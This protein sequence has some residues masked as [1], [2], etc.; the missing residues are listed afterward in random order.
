MSWPG[1]AAP[2]TS[3]SSPAATAS[4]SRLTAPADA[5]SSNDWN[6]TR[7]HPSEEARRT[8]AFSGP[9][10][11]SQG[12]TGSTCSRPRRA[13]SPR[14]TA[15]TTARTPASSPP[16]ASTA[17]ATCSAALAPAV[18]NAS[19]RALACA[20]SDGCPWMRVHSASPG[21]GGSGRSASP[22]PSSDT[23]VGLSSCDPSVPLS[24]PSDE[25]APRTPSM[26]APTPAPAPVPA[27]ALAPCRDGVGAVVPA[28]LIGEGVQSPAASESASHCDAAGME[29]M[30]GAEGTWG[31]GGGRC[32][33]EEAA[34]SRLG[35]APPSANSAA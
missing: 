27:P 8:R 25:P 33:G 17:T 34:A 9:V 35:V 13:A 28:A 7:S 14:S 26:P 1:S 15:A 2:A 30:D 16:P 21:R 10:N 24:P 6:P 5:A 11:P 32:A 3:T 23:V 4:Q 20:S 12:A 22:S 29:T 31:T 18:R 19:S